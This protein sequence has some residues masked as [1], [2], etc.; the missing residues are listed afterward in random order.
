MKHRD[1]RTCRRATGQAARAGAAGYSPF[2]PT[3]SG[4]PF[5][6]KGE[7]MADSSLLARYLDRAKAIVSLANTLINEFRQVAIPPKDSI[8]AKSWKHHKQI[9]DQYYQAI[10][11]LRHDFPKPP[12]GAGAVH[13]CLLEA[14][15]IARELREKIKKM[16]PEYVELFFNLKSN[17]IYLS[18]AIRDVRKTLESV[19]PLAFLDDAKTRIYET[20]RSPAK[21]TP[22]T[23]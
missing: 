10:L 13:D 15:K 18:E 22:T 23:G 7:I 3:G 1:G 2:T 19:D 8:D 21:P 9:S 12:E 5:P 4:Q 20:I 11:D 14:G 16:D 17:A 6:M